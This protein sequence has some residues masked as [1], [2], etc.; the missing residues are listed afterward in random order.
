MKRKDRRA[1]AVPHRKPPDTR[2]SPGAPRR[3]ARST[4]KPAGRPNPAALTITQ[5]VRL[6]IA[7]GSQTASGKLVRQDIQDGAPTNPDGSINLLHYTAWLVRDS[8]R[9]AG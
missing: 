5:L 6:L 3:P 1:A 2:A 9:D 4:R 7:G 8:G